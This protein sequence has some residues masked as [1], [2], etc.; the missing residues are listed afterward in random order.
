MINLLPPDTKKQLY[1]ARSNTLLVQYNILSIAILAL[2]LVASS[3]TFVYLN[4]IKSTNNDTIALNNQKVANY[5]SVQSEAEKLRKNLA[6]SK[7]V[8]TQGTDY[9]KLIL[10]ISNLLPKDTT[11]SNMSLS[12]A[13]FGVPMQL[14]V[15]AKNYN[16]AITLKENFSKSTLFSDV[17]FVS[18]V[19]NADA[20]AYPLVVTMNVTIKKDI[21]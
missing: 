12:A 5:A 1:A 9:P 10:A 18:I 20:G 6:A 19:Q 7:L 8:L 16:A 4:N 15:N 2:I 3:L 11:V 13:T 14:L 21:K 17:H